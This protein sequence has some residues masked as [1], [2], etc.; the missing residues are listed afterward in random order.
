MNQEQP[1]IGFREKSIAFSLSVIGLILMALSVPIISYMIYSISIAPV[2]NTNREPGFIIMATVVWLF[3]AIVFLIGLIFSF[4]Y[5]SKQA[6]LGYQKFKFWAVI[7][8]LLLVF[9]IPFTFITIEGQRDTQK[10]IER[11]AING[12]T[13]DQAINIAKNRIG[14]DHDY[15]LVHA[16]LMKNY[17]TD[18]AA[19]EIVYNYS[20]PDG[21]LTSR[22]IIINATDG[23]IVQEWEN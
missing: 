18:Y 6:N 14:S 17:S 8:L 16:E 20:K 4:L 22:Y 9:G 7:L 21:L 19:W 12:I 23:T 15:Q 13:Q 1:K 11:G 3:F 10:N 2:T 5:K